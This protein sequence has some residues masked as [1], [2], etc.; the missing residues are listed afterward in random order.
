MFPRKN[1]QA[2]AKQP[3]MTTIEELLEVVFSVG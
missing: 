3:P 2:I 1:N